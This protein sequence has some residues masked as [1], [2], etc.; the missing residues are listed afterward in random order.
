MNRLLVLLLPLLALPAGAHAQSTT[1]SDVI[2]RV[3]AAYGGA[4]TWAAVEAISETG[5]VSSIMRST[6]STIA[7]SFRHPGTLRV[8]IGRE[9]GAEVRELK[10]GSGWQNDKEVTGPQL[11]AMLLQAARMALPRNLADHTANVS[12]RGEIERDGARFRELELALG[13]GK[14][15]VVQI[16]PATWHIVRSIGRAPSPQ[17]GSG[18]I[19]FVTDY[20]DFRTVDGL[21]FP[22]HEINYAQGMKTGETRLDKI[23][24][25]RAGQPAHPTVPKKGKSG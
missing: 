23:H 9:N 7:R 14:S 10:D 15:L 25:S 18:T 21:L 8:E 20:L 12:D 2:A 13:D 24:V 4:E 6:E 19:E 11:D 1:A 17:F 22:F 3:L 5:H 16:D